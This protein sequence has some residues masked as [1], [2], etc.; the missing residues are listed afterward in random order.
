[1][2]GEGTRA[3]LREWQQAR[4]LEPTGFLAAGTADVLR[5]VGQQAVTD[6][7]MEAERLAAAADSI[8]RAEEEA[9][10]LAAAAERRRPGRVFSDCSVCPEMVVVAGGSFMMGSPASEEYREDNEGPRH[11]SDD[12][13]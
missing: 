3:A 12:R 7:V 5:R 1:M 10:R 13:A 8:A 9:Q 2:L 4:D 11:R 6:S